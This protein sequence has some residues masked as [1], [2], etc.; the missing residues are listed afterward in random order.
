M[1]IGN[2]AAM[3]GEL[4]GAIVR[5]GGLGPGS[6]TVTLAEA[7]MSSVSH[8]RSAGTKNLSVADAV[9]NAVTELLGGIPA[10]AAPVQFQEELLATLVAI[11]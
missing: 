7:E 3:T 2:C 1:V 4:M 8:A 10:S 9:T 5:V 11:V 6:C